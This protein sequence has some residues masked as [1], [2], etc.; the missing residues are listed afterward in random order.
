MEI[1]T[2]LKH[3]PIIKVENY[4][5]FDGRYAGDTDTEGLSIGIA[6]WNDEGNTELSAKVWRHTG[7]KWSRQSEELPLHRVLDLASLICSTVFYVKNGVLLTDEELS[8]TASHDEQQIQKLKESLE[9]DKTGIEHSLK[10][11]AK[12]LKQLGY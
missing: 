12:I 6:Q 7:E 4:S 11:L 10:R 5:K 9:K 2:H 8:I 1:P 3:K